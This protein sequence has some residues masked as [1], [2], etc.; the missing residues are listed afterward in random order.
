[1]ERSK[2]VINRPKTLDLMEEKYS[3]SFFEKALKDS[4]SQLFN[5]VKAFK[6]NTDPWLK[7]KGLNNYY[8]KKLTIN[9]GQNLSTAETYEYFVRGVNNSFLVDWE[10]SLSISDLP[11]DNFDTRKKK[12][13]VMMRVNMIIQENLQK[14]N[15]IPEY[16]F[17]NIFQKDDKVSQWAIVYKNSENGMKLYD[18]LLDG[19][20]HKKVIWVK[21]FDCLSKDSK[22]YKKT[23]NDNRLIGFV[24]SIEFDNWIIENDASGKE[25]KLNMED[26]NLSNEIKK[27][28]NYLKSQELINN[29][30]LKLKPLNAA[31]VEYY[32]KQVILYGYI[33]LDS[34]Y[35]FES[36]A[37]RADKSIYFENVASRADLKI[38]FTDV[39]SRAGWKNPSKKS[40]MY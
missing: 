31:K 19:K 8:R 40:L 36:V 29:P 28:E 37:S 11:I 35:N 34:Y 24:N 10:A 38:C 18:L 17:V 13:Y 12:D 22:S 2:S 21:Y 27:Y 32:D 26:P 1:M 15:D 30:P 39:K 14:K 16:F 7:V 6:A 33:N 4:I 5:L 9:Y 3:E 23:V 20:W 25:V